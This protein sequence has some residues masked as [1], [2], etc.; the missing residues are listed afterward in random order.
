M[1]G[2]FPSF[3]P[4]AGWTWCQPPLVKFYFLTKGHPLCVFG[5]NSRLPFPPHGKQLEGIAPSRAWKVLPDKCQPPRPPHFSIEGFMILFTPN[6]CCFVS[7]NTSP[8]SLS[9]CI[10]FFACPAI[11]S[12]NPPWIFCFTFS[13]FPG[14]AQL[15][16]P[17]HSFSFDEV[18]P[19]FLFPRLKPCFF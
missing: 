19:F 4:R 15:F 17:H 9:S 13:P 18:S 12:P 8:P 14:Y 16:F 2:Y 1:R 3:A 5:R 7:A 6:S 10:C 11:R